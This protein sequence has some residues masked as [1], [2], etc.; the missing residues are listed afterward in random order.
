[1]VKDTKF[2]KDQRELL[3]ALIPEYESYIV[4]HNPTHIK[5]YK[6]LTQWRKSKATELM[7]KTPFQ[8][9]LNNT[10]GPDSPEYQDW[11]E[12]QI[13]DFTFCL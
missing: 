4:T 6:G 5:R 12:V 1:M 9:M 2:D 10:S 11:H 7:K 3:E 13:Y 8:K